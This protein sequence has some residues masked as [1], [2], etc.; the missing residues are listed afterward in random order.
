MNR[1]RTLT[2]IFFLLYSFSAYA[3]QDSVNLDTYI[4]E[5]QIQ[6]NKTESGLYYSF[7]QEG[8]G[9][10]PQQGDYVKISFVGRLLNGV[11]FERSDPKEPFV[12]QLGYRQ[13]IL[14]LDKGISLFRVGSKGKLYI[15]SNL[16]YGAR[17]VGK[18]IRPNSDLIFEITIL[19]VMDIDAYD[20]FM[21]ELEKRERIEFEEHQRKQ[22]IEDKR[23][24]NAF[25]SEH[26]LKVK[27]TP[28][29]LSYIIKKKGK[30]PNI[31]SGNTITVHYEGYLLDDTIFDSTY[32]NKQPFKFQ[33]GKG[34]TIDGWEEGLLHFKKGSQGWLLIPSQL[35]YGPRS[36]EDD[37][38]NIPAD[39]VLI[40]KIKIVGLVN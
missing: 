31:V 35:A 14:G 6:V 21:E 16:G 40:F 13:V 10:Y 32:K 18:V 11:E 24:I 19:E 23:L 7:E 37:E 39:A 1:S 26:K 20:K 34:K 22:F 15:P 30:G 36:I 3:F 17:G 9:V 12:F 25:A 27:R 4:I 8:R 2:V 33:I 5:N 38:I 28:S 29:G